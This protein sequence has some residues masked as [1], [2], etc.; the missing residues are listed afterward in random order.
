VGFEAMKRYQCK[1]WSKGGNLGIT[2]LMMAG[3]IGGISYWICCYPLDMI[4]SR[5]QQNSAL[6]T[7]ILA[8]ARNMYRQEGLASFFKGFEVSLIRSIPSAAATF[9]LYEITLNQFMN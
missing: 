2:Q 8:N 3:S 7:S 1:N 5:I 4:K 6:P 9:T